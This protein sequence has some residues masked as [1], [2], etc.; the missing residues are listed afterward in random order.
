MMRAVVV[1]SMLMMGCVGASTTP[2]AP[3]GPVKETEPAAR[4]KVA[5]KSEPSPSKANA[6]EPAS[7]AAPANTGAPSATPERA[8]ATPPPQGASTARLLSA[9]AEPRQELRYVFHRGESPRWRL[10]SNMTMDT[11]LEAADISSTHAPQILHQILPTTECTG[12]TITQTVDA[13]GTAHRQGWIDGFNVLP[14]PGVEPSVQ[15]KVEEL[16]RGVGK[17]PFQDVIDTRG[18]VSE[19]HVDLSSVHDPTM[20][21]TLEQL[22]SSMSGLTAPWPLE[23]VGVGAKWEV[24]SVVGKRLPL[25]RTVVVTLLALRNKQLQLEM[26]SKVSGAPSRDAESG[27]DL[28]ETSASS[29]AQ[30]Y[31]TLDPL[32]NQSHSTTHTSTETTV[33]GVHVRIKLDT[34]T[35]FQSGP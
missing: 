26:S 30:L 14:T 25:T 12:T 13:D 32:S 3:E 35:E 11:V 28:G 7:S 24:Q 1:V 19:A 20:L 10:R 6:T 9:G 4:N 22:A 33:K 8:A 34:E 2:L 23:P 31:V 18:Q 17:I 27:V 29:T 15:S 16:L 21:K 5:T